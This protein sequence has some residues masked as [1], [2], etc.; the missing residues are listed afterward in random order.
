MRLNQLRALVLRQGA[1]DVDT[2][3]ISGTR[4]ADCGL[5]ARIACG[6]RRITARRTKNSAATPVL[7]ARLDFLGRKSILSTARHADSPQVKT[8]GRDSIFST[9]TQIQLRQTVSFTATQNDSPRLEVFCRESEGS[10]ATRF[11]S[12]QLKTR[13]RQRISFTAT[14]K[15]SSRLTTIYHDSDSPPQLRTTHRDSKR[16]AASQNDSPRLKVLYRDSKGLAAS[17]NGLPRLGTRQRS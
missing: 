15:D 4:Q 6:L 3:P 13:S 2:S 14:R 17:S 16:S 5:L 12:T 9:A 7:P 10:A 1:Q 8:I 11:H